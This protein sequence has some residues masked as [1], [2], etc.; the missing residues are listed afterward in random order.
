V[1]TSSK[2]VWN[3]WNEKGG[4]KY[5]HEKVVQYCFR[6]YPEQRRS[7]KVLDLGCG[8][9][10]H[11]VFLASEGFEVTGIDISDVGIANTYRKLELLGLKAELRIESADVLNFPSESFD[12]VICI[13]VY[14]CIGVVK[15]KISVDRV[16]MILRSG[17]R[18]LFIFPSDRDYRIKG[19][20]P[21]GLHGYTRNEVKKIFGSGFA[22]TYIDRYITTYHGGQTEK[23]DWI[24]T[25]ER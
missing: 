6:N 5:P 20:N 12:L 13:G 15:T 25:V 23:H 22:K 2:T 21:L 11:T 17:G 3:L 24:V 14:E 16:R 8:S 19:D 4:P 10:V 7:V 9:G 18:S 1:K